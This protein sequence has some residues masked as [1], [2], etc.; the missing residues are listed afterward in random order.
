MRIWFSGKISASQAEVAGSIPVICFNVWLQYK[1]RLFILQ[2]GEKMFE[3]IDLKYK[4]ILDIKH[5]IINNQITC[6]IGPSGSGKTTLLK[7]LNKLNLPDSGTILYNKIDISKI[8][9]I[10]LRR[11]IVML[12][13]T[14]IIYDGTIEDNLQIGLIFSQKP[15]A[16]KDIL[17]ETLNKVGI[18]QSLENTCANLSGGEKQ[19]ICL[20]RI[21]LMNADV[22]LLDEPSSSLDKETEMFIIQNLCK[23]VESNNKQ[24]IMVTHSEEISKIYKHS[25]IK[26]LD[27]KTGGYE[28]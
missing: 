25:C 17:I 8:E 16:E 22:Y 1:T 24:L 15:K 11:Q 26:I 3:V 7:H 21:I 19:R 6:I 20:A 28:L 12:G 9:T 5:I 13:Q 2:K 10:L 14:P 18:N 4:K 23:F 27:G